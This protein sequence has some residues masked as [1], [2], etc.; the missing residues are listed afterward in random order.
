MKT[1]ILKKPNQ[2]G[3]FFYYPQFRFL[4]MWLHFTDGRY[5]ISYRTRGL[6]QIYLRFRTIP[7]EVITYP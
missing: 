3:G 2:Y 7:T 1:R 6:A 5:P 4:G